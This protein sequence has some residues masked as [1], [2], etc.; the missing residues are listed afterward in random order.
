MGC[1]V[2]CRLCCFCFAESLVVSMRSMFHIAQ[3]R[4]VRLWLQFMSSSYQLVT[5][6]D[7]TLQDANVFSGQLVIIVTQL[8]DGT[9][10]APAGMWVPRIRRTLVGILPCL[11]RPR[12]ID[13]LHSFAL[14]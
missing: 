14:R 4:K 3:H 1:L 12:K 7:C 10:S 5:R 2:T 13:V 9:Y 6:F 8:D 11:L